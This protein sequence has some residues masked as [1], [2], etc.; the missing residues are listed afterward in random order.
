MTRGRKHALLIAGGGLAGSLAAL[1]MARLRPDVPI[2]LV[3]EEEKF[4]GDRTIFLI[5]DSLAPQER[6]LVLPLAEARWD[7]FYTAFPGRSRK[8]KLACLALSPERIDAAVRKTLR[9]DQYRQGARIVAVRDQSVL[10]QGGEKIAADGAIDARDN[11]HV[12]TLELGWRKSAARTLAFPAAHRVDLPVAADATAAQGKGCT[13]FSLLPLGPERLR[14]EEVQLSASPDF[15][16]DAAGERILSYAAR[17][18]W[19]DGAV[20][21]EESDVAPLALGGDFSA[22]W[23]LGGARVAKLGMRGGFFH[24]ATGC[25]GADALR[26]ASML[27][28]QRDYDGAL[29]HDGFEAEALALWRKREPFRAFNRQLLHGEGCSA[30]AAFYDLDPALIAR[31][32]GENLGLLDRRKIAALR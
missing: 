20:E 28:A 26:T 11:A 12:S 32:F 30:L 7:G 13:F 14:V 6:D 24:P 18:G 10:L 1:A 2:F 22:Y 17:R 8:L 5:E 29:L 23:R 25:Q 15:D 21:P 3:G 9:P 27:A 19:K 31:F 4:G 16:A